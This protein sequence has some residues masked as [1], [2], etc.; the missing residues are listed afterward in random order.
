MNGSGN[1]GD[2]ALPRG[3]GGGPSGF[4]GSSGGGSGSVKPLEYIMMLYEEG[5]FQLDDPVSR[6]IPEL[7]GMQPE[8]VYIKR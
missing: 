1:P 2:R 3:S 8:T 5:H 4:S 7:S 6:T